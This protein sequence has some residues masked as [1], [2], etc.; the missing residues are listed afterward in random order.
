MEQSVTFGDALEWRRKT[1]EV[2]HTNASVAAQKIALLPAHFA[3]V[4]MF[5]SCGVFWLWGS[6][7]HESRVSPNAVC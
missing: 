7:T 1:A 2:V 4:A 3:K 5:L 6:M